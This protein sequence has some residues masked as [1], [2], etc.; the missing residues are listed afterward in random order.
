MARTTLVAIEKGQRPVRPDELL[1]FS[2]LYSVSAGKLMAP[3]ANHVDIAAKFRRA[4][5]R[6]AS[7]ASTQALALLNR[8]ATGAAQ[9]E[10]L[11]GHKLHTDYPPPVRINAQMVNQKAED[12]AANLRAQLGLGVGPIPDLISLLE[13]E[14]CLRIFFGPL[15][16]TFPVFTPMIRR[17]AHAFSL[18]RTIIGNVG[19]RPRF[20]RRAVSFPTGRTRTFS[21]GRRARHR[22]RSAS[23]G[24]LDQPS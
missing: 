19:F 21:K 13:L 15:R 11:L 2:R 6:E 7:R 20:M 22:S 10:K 24:V 5:G 4:E 17:S 12:A 18:M 9:L 16:H 23:P 8:L 3:D 1:A 14:L